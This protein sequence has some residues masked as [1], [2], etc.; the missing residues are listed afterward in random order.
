[1]CLVRRPRLRRLLGVAVGVILLVWVVR[2]IHCLPS[3]RVE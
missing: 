2:I 1:L 3:C